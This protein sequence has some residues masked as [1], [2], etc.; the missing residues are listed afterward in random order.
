MAD[1][2]LVLQLLITAKDEASAAFGKLFSYLD[3]NTR[4]VANKIREAFTG[5]FGGALDGA[6]DFEA[7]L[8][9]VIAKGD[10]TYQSY[11]GLGQQIREVGIQ[12]GI[13]GEAA[14]KGMEALAAAGLSAKD[15]IGALPSV[16]AL[17]SSEQIS[18]DAAAQ[19]LIDSLSIMGLGFE[20]VG[21]MAD[22]LAK[23][24]NITTSSAS[25]LAEALSEAGGAARAVG[26][27][28]ESTVAAL[29]LLHKN[30]IK[31]SEAG[32]ALKAILTQLIDPSSQASAELTKLGISSRDLGVVLG[33][34]KQRGGEANA[35]ILAFGMEAGPGLRALIQEGQTGL[36]NYTQQLTDAKGAAQAAA[37][38]MTGNLKSAMASLISAWEAVKQSLLEPALKPL[39]EAAKEAANALQRSLGTEAFKSVQAAVTTFVTGSVDAVRQFIREFDF[40]KVGASLRDFAGVAKESLT[41]IQTAAQTTAAGVSLAWNT[42]ASGFRTIGSTLLAVAASAVQTLANM[43]QAASKVGLGSV[44]NANRLRDT[45]N[46]LQTKAS[47]L[48]AGVSAN[49]DRMGAAFSQLTGSTQQ[50]AASQEALKQALPVAELQTLT[51]TLAD[52]QRIADQA[53]A[54]A[55]QAKQDYE[56]GKITAAAYGQALL[57]A[58]E[59]NARLEEQTKAQTQA[60]KDSTDASKARYEAAQLHLRQSAEIIDAEQKHAAA[61]LAVAQAELKLA[62]ASGNKTRIAQAALEVAQ[63]EL[64]AAQKKRE[65]L[66]NELE[67]YRKIAER[68]Q[69][70]TARKD[71]LTA[72]EAAELAALKQKYPAI[73]TEVDAR[74]KNIQAI[75]RQIEGYRNEAQQAAV[76]AGPIGQLTR[77]YAEQTTEHER[78]AAAAE[79]Y[80]QTQ[81]QQVDAAIRVAKAK[82]NEAEAADLL[83]KKQQ[84]LIDQAAAMA[85]AAQQAAVDA[86]N[87]V[88]AYTLEAQ[89]TAGVTQA[90]QEQINKL[91]EV[92]DAKRAAAA[93][94]AIHADAV[95]QEAD[96]VKSANDVFDNA[97]QN[98]YKFS[99]AAGDVAK[100]NAE[101]GKSADDAAGKTEQLT[102]SWIKFRGEAA[103]AADFRGIGQFN[104]IFTETQ[105]AIE[106]A[107]LAAQR[108]A[109]EGIAAASG[110]AERLAQELLNSEGALSDAA[111]TAGQNLVDALRQAREEA[112]GLA[113]DM[114]GMAADFER[115]ILQIQGRQAELEELAYREKRAKLDEL[116]QRAGQIG[117][118]E[119]QDAVSKLEALHRLKLAKLDEENRSDDRSGDRAASAANRVANAWA[120]AAD[121]IERAGRAVANVG[122]ADLSRLSSQLTSLGT[123]AQT[124][125][126]AL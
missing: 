76:M 122:A 81:V 29:D 1:R 41:G 90:E 64:V 102:L 95:R 86:Q 117:D 100:R 9:R 72:A 27:D 105:A 20:Q 44:E 82:S 56:A 65:E 30:G 107:T 83:Q 108:L 112:Q 3:N 47:E 38:Q 109:D 121:E 53:N 35:A 99:E 98:A 125:A 80:Y 77:L 118:D 70:L 79:H 106:A 123:S 63:Q 116:H 55:A 110:S 25:Q 93:Q 94:A 26:M 58:A 46:S 21:R 119:Y 92:A 48:I 89:A 61:A 54:A 67:Q 39:A 10:E 8:D 4:V 32:T 78:A 126:G 49:A 124:L 52:Y 18:A 84:L 14:A 111:H 23:G 59:A 120:G 97:A 114:A 57:A 96:A 11:A 28:L 71:N 12:F 50:A 101:V 68:I 91:Q 69:D 16:L 31:G 37:D 66:Q 36:T 115:E 88:D 45:A 85:A 17:A 43:E 7:Q 51:A 103:T 24:A 22:V 6:L 19:K 104:R 33:Q 13:S 113:D 5:L 75:D 15:A 34:L 87:A 73:Q 62:E 60:T 40:S 2:N 74:E 42:L